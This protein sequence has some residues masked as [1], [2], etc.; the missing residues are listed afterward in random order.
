MKIFESHEALT[1]AIND[2]FGQEAYLMHG[3]PHS[4]EKGTLLEPKVTTGLSHYPDGRVFDWTAQPPFVF[5]TQVLDKAIWHATVRSH[6]V[7]YCCGM[8][9]GEQPDTIRF[10]AEPIVKEWVRLVNPVGRLAILSPDTFVTVPT[11]NMWFEKVSEA[12]VNVLGVY[13][14]SSRA[15]SFDLESL[16]RQRVPGMSDSDH[17]RVI[18]IAT[19][20][21]QELVDQAKKGVRA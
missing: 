17:E 8:T 10:M 16:P 5:A 13:A 7:G 1:A 6:G 18:G 4:I 9:A 14:V 12:R 19:T 2:D 11:P 3:T 15:L 21:M 20:R